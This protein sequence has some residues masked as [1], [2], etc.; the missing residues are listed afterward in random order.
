MAKGPTIDFR[1]LRPHHHDRKL[2]FEELLRQLLVADPPAGCLRFEHK[3]PGA[4][5]GVETLAYLADGSCWG[6]QSKFFLDQFGAS[7]MNQISGLRREIDRAGVE[8]DRPEIVEAVL[9]RH[10]VQHV[11]DGAAA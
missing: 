2:A 4:D 1:T 11:L 8:I 7:E 10:P 6:Y 5:G 3:G 9:R